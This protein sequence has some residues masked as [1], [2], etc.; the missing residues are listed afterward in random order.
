MRPRCAALRCAT[1]CCPPAVGAFPDLQWLLCLRSGRAADRCHCPL[2]FPCLT[3]CLACLACRRLCCCHRYAAALGMYEL[4]L[5]YMVVAHSQ[6]GV[7]G[8]VPMCMWGG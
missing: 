5:A 3:G 8:W 7:R 6:V 4:E 2:P 1:L